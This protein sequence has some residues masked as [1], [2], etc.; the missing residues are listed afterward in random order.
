[1]L[2][3]GTD[4]YPREDEYTL[5]LEQHGGESNAFTA[6]EDTHYFFDVQHAFLA[7]AL[8]RFAQF[9]LGPLFTPGAT[10]REQSGPSHPTAQRHRPSRQT[11]CS[12]QPFGHAVSSQ[13]ARLP[14]VPAQRVQRPRP[15]A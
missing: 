12:E 13:A 6:H 11:P 2:F 9:F 5:Y 1:M 7:G 8:D 15:L 10:A 3:L 14:A 4:K